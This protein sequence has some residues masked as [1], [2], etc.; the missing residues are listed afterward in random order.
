M[1]KK[2]WAFL[3]VI[4][5]L[6]IAAVPAFADAPNFG[7]AIYADGAAYGT[8][9]LNPL[10]PPNGHNDQSF[11][12]LYTF[13]GDAATGQLPVAEAAPGNPAYNG[14]RWSTHSVSWHVEPVL[15]TS[16]AQLMALEQAGD[17]EIV[18]TNNY[19]LCPLLPVKN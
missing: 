15:V 7:E 4:A 6:V 13:G 18:A 10:P 1:N 11:D 2:V 19:F 8:K 5:L 3:F 9:G 12:G 17:V 14:G 16:Y